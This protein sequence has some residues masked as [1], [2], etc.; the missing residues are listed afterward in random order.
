MRSVAALLIIDVVSVEEEEAARQVVT[1]LGRRAL[2]VATRLLV[3]VVRVET[4]T[5]ARAGDNKN[6][7]FGYSSNNETVKKNDFISSAL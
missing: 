1:V 4:A 5:K 6:M 3:L 2:D 7:E